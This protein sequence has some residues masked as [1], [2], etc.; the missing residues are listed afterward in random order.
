MHLVAAS[1]TSAACGMASAGAARLAIALDRVEEEVPGKVARSASNE[2]ASGT[3]NPCEYGELQTSLPRC[4]LSPQSHPP[5]EA[6]LPSASRCCSVLRDHNGANFTATISTIVARRR[7]NGRSHVSLEANDLARSHSLP[8]LPRLDPR[9]YHQR[10][11]DAATQL[12]SR[13]WWTTR[14]SALGQGRPSSPSPSSGSSCSTLTG[15]EGRAV[16]TPA[17]SVE[18]RS[19]APTRSSARLFV[20]ASTT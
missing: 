5:V 8:L 12:S 20:S 15:V 19:T 2:A 4:I 16:S 6:D 17:W 1:S 3:F 7:A 9:S 14:W 18:R 11:L 10:L 13:T